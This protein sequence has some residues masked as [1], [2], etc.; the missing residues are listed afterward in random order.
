MK[1]T[2]FTCDKCSQK[3]D[4]IQSFSFCVRKEADPS[5]NGYNPIY[6]DLDYCYTCLKD[7]VRKEEKIEEI[8][9]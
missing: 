5:G 7:L 1:I 6:K 9:I 2:C 8:K 3:S 4:K